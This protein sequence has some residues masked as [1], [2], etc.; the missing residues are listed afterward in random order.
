MFFCFLLI[1]LRIKLTAAGAKAI[2]VDDA[3]EPEDAGG[4]SAT[5]ANRDQAAIPSKLDA[6]DAPPAEAEPRSAGRSRRLKP[7]LTRPFIP[8][9]ATR[10]SISIFESARSTRSSFPG[11]RPMYACC[12][13]FLQRSIMARGHVLSGA[14]EAPIWRRIALDWCGGQRRRLGRFYSR[15]G[16]LSTP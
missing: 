14:G 7:Y 5:L 6:K 15:K 4:E 16:A 2:A 3:A 13:L 11:R 9:S 10:S 1:L 8:L 12:P